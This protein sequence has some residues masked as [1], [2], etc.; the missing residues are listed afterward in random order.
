LLIAY[1]VTYVIAMNL[2]WIIFFVPCLVKLYVMCKLYNN[3]S[4]WALI[5]FQR[6]SKLALGYQ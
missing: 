6:I 5:T 4:R 2:H 1:W 3:K